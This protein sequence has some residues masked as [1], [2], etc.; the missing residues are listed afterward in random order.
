M[1]AVKKNSRSINEKRRK[2]IEDEFFEKYEISIKEPSLQTIL[3]PAFLYMKISSFLY[4]VSKQYSFKLRENKVDLKEAAK[5]I[6]TIWPLAKRLPE[7][8][9]NVR[10]QIILCWGDFSKGKELRASTSVK[11]VDWKAFESIIK[12]YGLN[13]LFDTKDIAKYAKVRYRRLRYPYF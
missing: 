1:T 4:D 2:D 9:K 3:T 13:F 7:T 5:A 6:E 10:D 11:I 8:Q 12:Y